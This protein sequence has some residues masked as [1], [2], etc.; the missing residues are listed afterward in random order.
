MPKSA[1]D[2]LVKIDPMRDP[3]HRRET[4]RPTGPR[5][6]K[7]L[8]S[9]IPSIRSCRAALQDAGGHRPHKLVDIRLGGRDVPDCPA[10]P[11]DHDPVRNL[12]DLRH[13]VANQHDG[14]PGFAHPSNEIEDPLESEQHRERR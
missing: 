1:A 10:E 11:Q 6:G 13:V 3:L 9:R 14:G 8:R 12:H 7:E 5:D 2:W 4:A